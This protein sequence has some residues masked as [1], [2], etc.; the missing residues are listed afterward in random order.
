LEQLLGSARRPGEA[1][2]GRHEDIASSLQTVFERAA[3]HVLNALWART[4][5]PRLCVAG[6]CFMNSVLNGRIREATPFREIFIQPAAGDNGTALGAAFALWNNRLGKPR[7]FA[8]E[9]AH[10]G[11]HYSDAEVERSLAALDATDGRFQVSPRLNPEE[12]C[13]MT[14]KL[15]AEG[16]VVG[17]FRGRMEWGSRAL[18]ARSILADP[19]RTEMHRRINKAIK[20]R[21]SFRPFAPSILEAA[22]PEYFVGAR[23]DPFMV[24]VYPVTRAKWNV[25]PAVTHVDG[26]ARPHTVN[27]STNPHYHRVIREF[28]HITSIPMVLNTSF[29]ENEP[30]VESPQQALDCFMRTDMDAVALENILVRRVGRDPE[31]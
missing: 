31:R 6:G 4:R 27:P 2:T 12:I 8:M 21:E 23:P 5:N 30:I 29:N 7:S 3:I 10:L 24:Q 14:A 22:L 20:A 1:L 25:I 13:R 26:T 28:A 9:H 16:A 15:I 11:T 17:W 19:R 18:G